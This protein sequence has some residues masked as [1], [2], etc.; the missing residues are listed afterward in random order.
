MNRY[1]VAS[2]RRTVRL[3]D[4]PGGRPKLSIGPKTEFDSA[5]VVSIVKRRG[6]W[7][8]VLVPELENGEI[9]WIREDKLSNYGT[10]GWA[11]H[12]DL[13]KRHIVVKK[14]GKRVRALRVGIGRADH[15]TP[16]GRY[17]VTDKLRVNQPGSPYGCCVVA[18]TGHQTKLPPGLAR[19]RPPGDPRHRAT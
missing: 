11:I 4:A 6:E 18:L 17:A 5:R 15:P 3:L 7:V 1:P 13:S 9:G 19:G 2:V 12:V 14:D 8:A 10:V 16:N